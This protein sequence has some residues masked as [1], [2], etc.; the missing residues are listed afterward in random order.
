MGKSGKNRMPHQV[1]QWLRFQ[2]A[3]KELADAGDFAFMLSTDVSSYF[4][5]VDLSTL[6]KELKA[7]PDV[8]GTVVD[9]LSRLLN[10][11]ERSTDVWGCRRA[12]R[13]RPSLATSTY[14]Q[15]IDT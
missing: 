10:D 7:L 14:C 12:R 11:V 13:H 2:R 6:S 3:G 5:Y 4:E 15:S 8:D 1:Q 9:L